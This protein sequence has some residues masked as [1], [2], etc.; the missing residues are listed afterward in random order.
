MCPGSK[1]SGQG[2]QPESGKKAAG[3][4]PDAAILK[5][6]HYYGAPIK[7]HLHFR[8]ALAKKKEGKLFVPILM[9]I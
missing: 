9:Q 5:K 8:S 4:F 1:A 3:Y 6:N 7:N 2:R